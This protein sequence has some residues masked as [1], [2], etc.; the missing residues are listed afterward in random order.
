M[1]NWKTGY[2][3][4]MTLQAGDIIEDYDGWHHVVADD[5]GRISQG[6]LI[7]KLAYYPYGSRVYDT[8]HEGSDWDSYRICDGNGIDV[9]MY[10]TGWKRDAY[11]PSDEHDRILSVDV[12]QQE[13]DDH[14]M[15]AMECYF[16]A[17]IQDRETC[18]H[19][20][21]IDITFQLNLG[22][23]RHV[24]SSNSW[25][26]AKKKMEVEATKYEEREC[27]FHEEIFKGKKS[28]FHCLRVIRFG[29]Q[30]AKTGAIHDFQECTSLWEEIHEMEDRKW[31]PYK[32]KYQSLRNKWMSEFRQLAPKAETS[33]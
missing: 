9:K 10:K 11:K 14:D 30:I 19:P 25:V 6:P 3:L 8:V 31:L 27:R 22:K 7:R 23:L 4:D 29:I 32:E 33:T 12:F 21:T 13:L 15:I 5:Q 28:L 2:N 20:N 17:C 18:V 1:T 24:I 26:K 16:A